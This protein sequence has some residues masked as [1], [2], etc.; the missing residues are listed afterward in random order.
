MKFLTFGFTL[1]ALMAPHFVSANAF[2]SSDGRSYQPIATE[3]TERRAASNTPINPSAPSALYK[4][5]SVQATDGTQQ[6]TLSGNILV[7]VR[8]NR[9]LLEQ[10]PTQSTPFG[11]EFILL[12]FDESVNL[13]TQQQELLQHLDVESAELEVNTPKRRLR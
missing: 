1:L 13:L 12:H 5:Q 8:S 2:T 11:D 4:G 6:G 10:Y 9:A 7:K 3:Q